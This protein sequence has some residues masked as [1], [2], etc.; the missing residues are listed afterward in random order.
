MLRTVA[1]F[2]KEPSKHCILSSS[3]MP[4]YKISMGI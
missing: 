1:K 3:K 4:E 2:M